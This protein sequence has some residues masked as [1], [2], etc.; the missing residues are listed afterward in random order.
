MNRSGGQRVRSSRASQPI[1][2]AEVRRSWIN[3]QPFGPSGSGNT[4]DLTA[5][6]VFKGPEELCFVDL[7]LL[8]S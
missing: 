8:R 1:W 7:Q 2:F 5:L 6:A 4:M 3:V